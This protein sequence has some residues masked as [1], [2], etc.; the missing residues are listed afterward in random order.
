M[1][2]TA[3]A[4]VF[5]QKQ[6]A[7]GDDV[8]FH[9]HDFHDL[10]DAAHA[11]A[12]ALGLNDEIERADQL[13]PDRTDRKI[14][15]SH[16]DHVFDARQ[17][18]ASGVGVN[19]GHGTVVTGV[20][21]LHHVER[22]GAANLPDN[23]PVRP[24]SQRVAHQIA[25][26]DLPA[27]FDIGRAGLQGEDM[28]LLQLEF[29][30]V[31]DG[32]DALAGV[33]HARERVE[34]RRLAGAGAAGD[35]DVQA[36]VRDD[37][38][39]ARKLTRHAAVRHEA[40]EFEHA[41]G[42][43]SNG[44]AG[45]LETERRDDH[46]DAAAVRQSRVEH[47][48]RFVDAPPD[49]RRDALGDVKHLRVAAK[50]QIGQLQLAAPLDVDHARPVDQDVRYRRIAQ[51]RVDRAE[52]DHLVDDVGAEDVL[53]VR[54]QQDLSLVRDLRHQLD[55]EIRQF[56][57]ADADGDQRFDPHEDLIADEVLGLRQLGVC[58][59]RR[60]IADRRG[61]RLHRGRRRRRRHD[62]VKTCFSS[63]S[64]GY[65]LASRKVR[66]GAGIPSS[67]GGLR[68]SHIPRGRRIR[69]PAVGPGG[70]RS[71]PSI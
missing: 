67:P 41:P 59:G 23:D 57:L 70:G 22:F 50:L 13:G 42:E 40:R 17:R 36:A 26:T 4:L 6:R 14:P 21:R 64:H 20:H 30:G 47:R 44:K 18:L 39:E 5:V 68:D 43:L 29:G 56:L 52:P 1:P 61:R 51:Q 48:A 65:R 8:A 54:V 28:G 60:R 69:W 38:Q 55:D 31:L 66:G 19:G 27:S 12:H 46:V 15:G 25:L 62:R 2:S 7:E 63:E 3:L 16:Q 10:G 9:A 32:D 71:T 45:A 35:D 34:Q 33:D 49:R 37:F 53:F 11:V 58:D 24:H